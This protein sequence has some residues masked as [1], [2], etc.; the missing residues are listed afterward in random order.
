VIEFYGFGSNTPRDAVKEDQGYYLVDAWIYDTRL[1]LGYGLSPFTW[2]G[3]LLSLNYVEMYDTRDRLIDEIEAREHASKRTHLGTGLQLYV[4]TRE[5]SMYPRSGV[6]V[7]AKALNWLIT[8]PGRMPYQRLEAD[9]RWYTSPTSFSDAVLAL[10]LGGIATFGGVPFYQT[11]TLGGRRSL[12]GYEFERFRGDHS[13][14]LSAEVRFPLFRQLIVLPFE[15]G[16]F[17]L[18]D[19]GRLWYGGESPGGWRT[20]GGIGLWGSTFSRELLGVLYIAFAREKPVIRAGL[21]FDY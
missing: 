15:F 20:D 7:D 14:S 19:A 10:R 2:F 1:F 11:A 21:G 18:G 8:S 3:P 13:V 12:R 16:G 9:V 5:G 6:Y 4:D 17:L